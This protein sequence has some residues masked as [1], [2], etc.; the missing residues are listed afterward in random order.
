VLITCTQYNFAVSRL[1][2][3]RASQTA[4]QRDWNA[5]IAGDAPADAGELMSPSSV[6][7][8]R[9]LVDGRTGRIVTVALEIQGVGSVSKLVTRLADIEGVV[10]VTA[11]DVNVITD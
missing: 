10:A 6:D 1:Q 5:A 3:E 11:G 2:L 9:K 4:A 8:E 7:T